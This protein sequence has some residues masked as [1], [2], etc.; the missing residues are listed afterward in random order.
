[1]DH[2]TRHA[3]TDHAGREYV[4]VTEYFAPDTASTGVL[5][6][7]LAVGLRR[8]GLDISVLTSQPNYHSG[9]NE[10]Q[11]RETVHEG[12]PVRRIR[13]PQLRQSS[14]PRR[15]FNWAVFT[16]VASLTLLVA[17]TDGRDRELVFVS[18]PPFLP[19]AMWLVATLR[20][21]G[22]TYVVYDLYPDNLVE[23][24]YLSRAGVAAR[25]WS[26]LHRRVFRAARAVVA[27]GPAMRARVVAVAGEGFDPGSVAVVHNWQDGSF[28]VPQAKADNWFSRKHDLV[29]RFTLVYSGNIGTFHDLDTVVEAAAR[30]DAGVHF[31]VVGEGDNKAHVR[32]LAADLGLGPDRI[33]FLP[34]QDWEV[35]PDSLTSGDVMI[36]TVE[37]GFEGLCVS[38]KL[39]TALATGQPVL[40]VARPGSDEARIVSAF[41]AG[42]RVTQGDVAGVV[43]AID[44]W[45]DDPERYERQAANARRAFE[46]HFTRDRAVDAYYTLL[47]RGPRFVEDPTATADAGTGG[48]P[49]RTA[50]D[51]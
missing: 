19:P 34:Y 44:R 12:V 15:L 45:R 30:V 25:A 14:L 3:D 48:D 42:E 36:V 2:D 50:N 47:T 29:D 43:A 21:W 49:P 4:L 28:V 32:G 10:R 16:L 37:E 22:Y 27:L 11:P 46:A 18:N 26:W 38:S 51:D 35:V 33:T 20:G 13:A 39:Y 24:G 6:T 31:L 40:C 9:E 7:D 1:M 17:R 8:R 5:M 23:L 41:D